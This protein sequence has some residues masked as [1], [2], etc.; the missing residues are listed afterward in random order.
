[1]SSPNQRY[2]PQPITRSIGKDQ[3]A[4]FADP[5][6]PGITQRLWIGTQ[7]LAAILGQISRSE[8]PFVLNSAEDWAAA[9]D[10]LAVSLLEQQ[11][12]QPGDLTPELLIQWLRV[13]EERRV[14]RETDAA[15][16]ARTEAGGPGEG[17]AS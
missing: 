14:R 16:R 15:E 3:I 12:R 8:L 6:E 10:A 17:G 4:V 11:A 9:A 1:M 13:A 5:A 2:H 7:I